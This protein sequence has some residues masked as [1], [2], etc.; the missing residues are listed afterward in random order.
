MTRAEALQKAKQTLASE[1]E[2]AWPLYWAP[3]ILTGNWR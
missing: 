1:P 3:F 2:T